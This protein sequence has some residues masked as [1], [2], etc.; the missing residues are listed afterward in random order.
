[1]KLMILDKDDPGDM[2]G[3][4]IFVAAVFACGVVIGF[5]IDNLIEH[6]ALMVAR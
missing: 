1:M 6:F 2:T 3:L 5:V 4:G